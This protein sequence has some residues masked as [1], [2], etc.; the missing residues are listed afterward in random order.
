MIESDY[1]NNEDFI[2]KRVLKTKHNFYEAY[3]PLWAIYRV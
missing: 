3:K 2:S 1:Y